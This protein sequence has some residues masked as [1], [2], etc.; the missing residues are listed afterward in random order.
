MQIPPRA[1]AIFFR[2][3]RSIRFLLAATIGAL[4]FTGCAFHKEKNLGDETS[5]LS[6]QDIAQMSYAFVYREVFSVSCSGC[7]GTSGGLAFEPEGYQVVKDRIGEI[8][9]DVFAKKSMPKAP[10]PPLNKRQL[11]ILKE[12]IRMGMPQ[13]GQVPLPPET[14]KPNYASIRSMIL[15]KRCISC[16]SGSGDGSDYPLDLK[17]M[18]TRNAIDSQ[19]K[20]VIPGDPDNS[21][22][23]K[24]LVLSETDDDLMPPSDSG[25]KKLTK[26]EIDTVRAWIKR[27]AP[28]EEP[29]VP[30]EP[31]FDSIDTLILQQRCINCHSDFEEAE[32]YPLDYQSLLNN[33]GINSPFKLVIPGDPENSILIMRLTLPDTNQGRMPPPVSINKKLTPSE[34]AIIR[35][36]IKQGAPRK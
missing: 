10:T 17:S 23:L 36:W 19:L 9:T 26:E 5:E 15:E 20:V 24:R 33:N 2:P 3:R 11:S 31:N 4:A 25:Y 1:R 28:E 8:Q 13:F 21:A 12:W 32:K 18:L 6:A 34:I 22:F 35:A 30:L 14:L 27:G 7:H 16:H 29:T